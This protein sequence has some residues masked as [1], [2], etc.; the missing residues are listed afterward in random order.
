M[1][2]PRSNAEDTVSI[3]NHLLYL[4]LLKLL[5]LFNLRANA[6]WLISTHQELT[7]PVEVVPNFRQKMEIVFSLF[8]CLQPASQCFMAHFCPPR[9]NQTRGSGTQLPV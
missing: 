2:F 7:R 3:C 4:H 8:L 1:S 6:S 9:A 5:F